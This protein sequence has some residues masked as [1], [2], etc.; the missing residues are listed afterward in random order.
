MDARAVFEPRGRDDDRVDERPLD[1]V[2]HGWLVALVDDPHRNQEHAGPDVERPREQEIDVGLFQ[3]DFALF[4][5]PF[6]ERVFQFELRNKANPR[7]EAVIHDEDEP[8]EV[9]HAGGGLFFV[10][11]KVHVAGDWSGG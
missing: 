9:E 7:R 4:F 6:D 3:L 10:E 1:A 8:M 11:V 5:E 2:K